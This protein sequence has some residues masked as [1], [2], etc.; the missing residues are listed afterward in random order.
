MDL[1]IIYLSFNTF[2]NFSYIQQI[3]SL[4]FLKIHQFELFLKNVN[5][6]HLKNNEHNQVFINFSNFYQY[7]YKKFYAFHVILYYI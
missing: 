7:I 1:W 2:F 4:A 3:F 6:D 5:Y